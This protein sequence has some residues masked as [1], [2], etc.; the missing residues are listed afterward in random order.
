MLFVTGLIFPFFFN[1]SRTV[2][3]LG[4]DILK[5]SECFLLG[6]LDGCLLLFLIPN[7]A[8][9]EVLVEYCVAFTS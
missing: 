6:C 4:S 1:V 3:V 7:K 9:V 5:Q 2:M 8:S